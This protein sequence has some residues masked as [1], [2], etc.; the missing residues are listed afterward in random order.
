MPQNVR[1]RKHTSVAFS[2]NNK[3]QEE[4]SRGSVLREIYLNLKSAPT[5][6]GANNTAANTAKGDDWG[7]VKKIEIIANGSE[8]VRSLSGEALRM[9]NLF[10]YGVTPKAAVNLGDGATAN[11]SLSSTLVLPFWLPNSRRPIDTALDTKQLSELTIEITWGTYTDINSAATA[12]TTNP[13]MDVYVLESFGTLEN[14]SM[15]RINTIEKEIVASSSEFQVRLPVNGMYRQ[16]L[17][18]TTDAG[19]D[20]AAVINNLKLESGST[21][22]MDLS[23]EVLQMAPAIRNGIARPFNGQTYDDMFISANSDFEGWYFLDL[24]T[25]GLMSEII[26]TLGFSEFQMTLDVTVGGGTTKLYMWPLQVFPIRGK[27][28][29]A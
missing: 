15:T 16:F 28:A 24:A 22:F 29:A 25:D 21:V 7:V 13:S 23:E 2:A 6:T 8:V 11:P 10:Y 9:L 4:L 26:D 19:V 5:L 14:Y 1:W 17:I 3:Q 18:N 27:Q 20:D 12:W